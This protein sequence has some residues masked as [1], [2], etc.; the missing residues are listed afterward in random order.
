MDYKHLQDCL[1]ALKKVNAGM[2]E[3]IKKAKIR[4]QVLEVQ[5]QFKDPISLVTPS[6]YFVR[7]GTLRDGSTNADYEFIL[8]NDL[9]LQASVISEIGRA[10]QQECRDRSRM[11]SSA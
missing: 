1:V 8:F 9:L 10:V 5:S 6:R 2:N 3:E 11:P 7:K 4:Q